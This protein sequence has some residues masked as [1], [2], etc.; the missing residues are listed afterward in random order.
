[1]WIHPTRKA[2]NRCPL[3]GPIL[4]LPAVPGIANYIIRSHFLVEIDIAR[5]AIQV[6]I[7]RLIRGSIHQMF[8]DHYMTITFPATI[9]A[10]RVTAL[11]I[12]HLAA[13]DWVNLLT[14]G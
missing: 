7:Q 4:I 9:A 2:R 6:C 12:D 11:N 5:Y 13:G 14:F 8:N 3:I 10:T 1:M